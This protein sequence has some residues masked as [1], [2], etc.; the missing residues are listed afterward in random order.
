M[1]PGRIFWWRAGVINHMNGLSFP[2]SRSISASCRKRDCTAPRPIPSTCLAQLR[3]CSDCPLFHSVLEFF[4]ELYIMH[5]YHS[6]LSCALVLI[7]LSVLSCLSC[8]LYV[9]IVP[10]LTCT[11]S[12]PSSYHAAVS[13]RASLFAYWSFVIL[14]F[15]LLLSYSLVSYIYLHFIYLLHTSNSNHISFTLTIFARVSPSRLHQYL[16]SQLVLT[17]NFALSL[18]N[19]SSSDSYYRLA[20]HSS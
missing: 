19:F 20:N 4:I 2:P 5:S 12:F 1:L 16:M 17:I 18:S 10:S 8:I 13:S 3:V 9:S 7:L 11:S 14:P 6:C 15:L